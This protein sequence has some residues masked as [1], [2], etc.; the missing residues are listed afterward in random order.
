MTNLVDIIA[1]VKPTA[2]FGLSTIKVNISLYISTY[3]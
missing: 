1:Y 2:L 3:I